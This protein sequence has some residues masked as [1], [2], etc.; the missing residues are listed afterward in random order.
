MVCDLNSEPESVVLGVRETNKAE[1][2][3]L[4]GLPFL[5]ETQNEDALE[6]RISRQSQFQIAVLIPVLTM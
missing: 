3:T 6:T 1:I 5:T 4:K 2:C